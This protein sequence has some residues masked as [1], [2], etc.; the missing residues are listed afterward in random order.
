[1]GWWGQATT[2]MTVTK[3]DMPAT[4][5]KTMMLPLLHKGRIMSAATINQ[6]EKQSTI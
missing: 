4:M 6:Y 5:T 1:M 3:A 2:A